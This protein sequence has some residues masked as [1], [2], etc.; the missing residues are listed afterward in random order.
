MNLKEQFNGGKLHIHMFYWIVIL[1]L[2]I[3]AL[4]TTRA[5][6]NESLS[7][8]IAFGATLSGIILSVIAIIMTLI[9]ESKSDNTKDK[10]V[11]LSENLEEIVKRIENTTVNLEDVFKTNTEVKEHLNN[12]ENY[13]VKPKEIDE[14]NNDE[15]NNKH[16][17]YINIF[18]DVCNNKN[19][20][21][22]IKDLVITIT[23]IIEKKNKGYTVVNYENYVQDNDKLNI[24]NLQPVWNMALV[25][26]TG[27]WA[28]KEFEDF[29]VKYCKNNYLNEYNVLQ[30]I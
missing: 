28:D 5:Y 23:Y 3:V 4:F 13:F 9:G 26:T 22:I 6:S 8:Q 27:I 25:F 2:I 14:G 19:I 11:N 18:N 20:N 30:N 16:N 10:L 29:I 1:V 21:G 24:S 7:D 15:I 12:I 17:C